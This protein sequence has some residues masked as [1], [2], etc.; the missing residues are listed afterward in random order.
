MGIRRAGRILPHEIERDGVAVIDAPSL[1]RFEP[2]RA[3]AQP[4]QR[5]IDCAFGDDV[6][7]AA[8]REARVIA[9]LERGDRIE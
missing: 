7:R 6:R 8:E 1:D 4:L 9:R 5:L 3:L 2:G